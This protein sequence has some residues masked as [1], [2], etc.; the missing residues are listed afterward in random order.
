METTITELE[1]KVMINIA[2]SEYID[3]QSLDELV[4]YPTWSFVATD[5]S[6]QLKGA[7]GSLVKKG[8]VVCASDG[9]KDDETCHLTASGV[10]ALKSFYCYK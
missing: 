4:D 6:N 9:N 10:D 1:Q 5:S 8:L 2:E 3:V 7:L